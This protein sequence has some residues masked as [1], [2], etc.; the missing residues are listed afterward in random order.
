MVESKYE[1]GTLSSES[2]KEAHENFALF[3]ADD[4]MSDDE[5]GENKTEKTE[6]KKE[7]QTEI[8]L[9]DNQMGVCISLGLDVDQKT[10]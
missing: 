3:L 1:Y 9:I 4:A 2:V 6:V 5:E 7:K 10:V 8:F